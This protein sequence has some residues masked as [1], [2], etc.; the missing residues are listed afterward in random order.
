SARLYGPNR[1]GHWHD[2]SDGLD[3]AWGAAR[4]FW[5]PGRRD[6]G[7]TSGMYLDA[8]LWRFTAG[9]RH[10]LLGAVGIGLISAAVGVLRL[11]LLGWLLGLVFDGAGLGEL[12][13]PVVLVGG[14]MLLRAG[15]EYSRNMVAHRTAAR[16]Q[17][18]LRQRLYEQR[19]QPHQPPCQNNIHLLMFHLS[20]WLYLYP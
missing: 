2:G 5:P 4:N 8:R 20:K 14:A 1:L 18:V 11:M 10:R 19:N 12:W 16:V 15:L 13:G 6:L 7:G 9:L 17:M 3:C